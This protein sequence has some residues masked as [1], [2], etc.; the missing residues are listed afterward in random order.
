MNK[1]ILGLLAPGLLVGL[2]AHG[3]TYTNDF[4]NPNATGFTLNGGSRP[5]GNPYPAIE[6]GHLALTYA[7][8]SEN[9]T[10]VMDELDAGK[11]VAGFNAT[12]KLRIGGGSSSPADGLSFYYGSDIDSTTLI[13]EEGFHTSTSG[14]GINWDVWDNGSAEAP[15]IDV[16]VNNVIVAAAPMSILEVMS[17]TFAPVSI[18]LNTNGVL[19]LSYKGK[20]V[21]TNVYLNGWAPITGGRF[22]IGARTGGENANHWVSELGITTM[23]A[24]SPAAP[25][26]ITAPANQTINEHG[27]VAFSLLPGGTPP[28]AFEWYSNNVIIPDATNLTLNLANVPFTA[29]GVKY[30]VKVSNSVGNVSAEAT[31]AVNAD[32]N[33]P[34]V[35]S[36]RGTESF[37]Q[38]IVTF[39]ESVT[40]ASAGTASNYKVDGGVTVSSVTVNSATTVT[41]NTSAQ[42]PGTA[43]TL[44]INGIKDTATTPNT[45][46]TDTKASFLAFVLANGFLKHEYWGGIADVQVQKLLDDPR[47]QANQPDSVGFLSAFT[48]RTI[49]PDDSHENYGARITGFLIPQETADYYLF[50]SSDD[51]SELWLST[52][53][54]TDHLEKIAEETGCCNAFTEPGGPRTSASAIHLVAGQRYAVMALHKEG[55]GGDYVQVAW[56]KEGDTT[57]A[58]SL[59]PIP[60]KFL[61]TYANPGIASVQISKQ[62]Q[63][64]TAAEN[65]VASFS[66]TAT[67]SPAPVAYQW[68]R[69]ESGSTN[70]K[71]IA[72]ATG[73]TYTTAILKQS[74][75]NGAAFR[76]LISVPGASATSDTVTLTVNIDSLKPFLTLLRDGDDF[77]SVKVG[78]SEPV[79]PVSA[80]TAANYAIQGLTITKATLVN[81]SN[82]VLVTSQQAE[83]TTYTLVVSNVKD[84]AGNVIDPAGNTKSFTSFVYLSGL[85][86]FEAFTGFGGTA[87]TDLT[88]NAKYPNY[89]DDTRVVMGYEGI[90]GYG[91]NYGVKLS[92]FITPK[93]SGKYIFYVASDDNSELYLST[94]DTEANVAPIAKEVNWANAR[95]WTGDSGGRRPNLENV[96]APIQLEAGKRYYTMLLYKEGGGGDHG[97]VAMK[98]E[99]DPDP[100]NGSLP[101]WG[102]LIGTAVD[103]A[104][105]VQMSLPVDLASPIGSGDSSKPGI[106][107]RVY[108]VGQIG[109]IIAD[110]Q[111]SSAEQL[112]AGIL[113]P[114]VADLTGS[115]NGVW[116]QGVINW[117]VEMNAGGSGTEIGSF[118]SATTPSRMDDPMP[119]M[120]GTLTTHPRDS[121]A[122][123][124]ITYAE[125]PKAG[126]Y[127]MG[128]NSDDGFKV[129]ATDKAPVFNGALV[130]SSPASIAKAYGA[131]YSGPEIGGVFKSFTGTISG[132]LVYVDPPDACSALVNADAIKGNIA[133]IDRGVCTFSVKVDAALKAGA[134]AAVIVNSRDPDSADGKWPIV[135]GGSYVDLPAVMITKTD[136]AILK[137][138]IANG[139]EVS[140]TRDDSPVLGQFIGTRGSGDSLFSFYVS[141]P[142]LYPLRCAWFQGDGGS[143]LEWFTLDDLGNKVLLNDRTSA[144]AIKTYRART[145]TPPNKPTITIGKDGSGVKITWTGKLES[146]SSVAGPWVEE[147]GTSPL[148]V[149]NPAG[150]KF[151]RAKQ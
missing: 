105:L 125:F 43:Y 132:K 82:V 102:D 110:T 141:Q 95:E 28:F 48:S 5:N 66:V 59:T 133:L 103:P 49:F 53:S 13:D 8:N 145:Y 64:K 135:M 37:K 79:D 56:R 6:G 16:R 80:A 121:V 15:A 104:V 81:A 34:T 38:V 84:S 9:G 62:P 149:G 118:T 63:S 57:A 88:G 97:A 12:F 98:L 47:Y 93:T 96:S 89:P 137:S 124:L 142:G 139:I 99:S 113:G 134:I 136:G 87:V 75:D 91:D 73:S 32:T 106:S 143:N 31:L 29:N 61:A 128:V 17:D 42:T 148:T 11:S 21:F 24:G 51:A 68:Q 23:L 41:L 72:G 65:T 111:I 25:V 130:V 119:G 94:D 144:K 114:N 26:L 30:K 90:N 20:V 55:G 116:S 147:T 138:V 54:S 86:K 108:Q 140:I 35:V 36:A 40:A 52:D 69:A 92:G 2:L 126:L 101:V 45:I 83:K 85:A 58:G 39:S 60:G 14:V 71:D 120:P 131:V 151:Y 112:L 7:E 27:S 117:N 127:T 18:N 150:A 146:A 67:G 115:V 122:A 70:F 3:A 123:E 1:K 76:V 50:L 107:A 33:A 109:G 4:S 74:V 100:E 46:A 10:F 19:N 129:T 77:K 78:F 22:A 44:T